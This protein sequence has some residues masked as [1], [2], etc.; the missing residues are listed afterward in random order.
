M[1]IERCDSRRKV[2]LETKAK[3]KPV[4]EKPVKKT[5][6]KPADGDVYI[7]DAEAQ[8]IEHSKRYCYKSEKKQGYQ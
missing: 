2:M 5:V 8:V 6:E 3:D 4:E 1:H 7:D